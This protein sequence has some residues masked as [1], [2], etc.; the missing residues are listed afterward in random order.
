M[1]L[2][3]NAAC[4]SSANGS[5]HEAQN[6]VRAS[7]DQARGRG[8]HRWLRL[9][10]SA[11]THCGGPPP[12]HPAKKRP[13]RFQFLRSHSFLP[14]RRAEP[15][16]RLRVR[17]SS[18]RSAVTHARVSESSSDAAKATALRIVR[19]RLDPERSLADRRKHHVLVEHLR[20]FARRAETIYACHGQHNRVEFAFGQAC[21][22]AYR[23][24]RA[25]QRRQ[26]RAARGE[27]APGAARCLCRCA[28]RRPVLSAIGL[29]A[30]SG[31]RADPRAA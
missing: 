22:G 5:S 28:R 24:C 12:C 19:A 11:M 9:R 23:R 25:N 30:K 27:A 1:H 17:A 7:V 4:R 13:P 8:A 20:H 29:C 14:M 10:R 31:N 18:A 16:I 21:V 6:S 15:G 26:D 3:A 2:P